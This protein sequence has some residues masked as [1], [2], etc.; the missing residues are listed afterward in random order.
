MTKHL[1]FFHGGVV[2]KTDVIVHVEAE[3]R[4]WRQTDR[5]RTI[6]SRTWQCWEAIMLQLFLL[7][8]ALTRF[9]SGFGHDEVVKTVMLK[10]KNRLRNSTRCIA[11]LESLMCS[12]MWDDQILLNV[13]ELLHPCRPA[14]GRTCE[15]RSLQYPNTNRKEDTCQATHLNNE[16]E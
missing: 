7:W 11:R 2:H 6:W 14:E 8:R 15:P 10:D 4:P 1:V 3:K 13:H 16:A 9:A 12:Y 5:W